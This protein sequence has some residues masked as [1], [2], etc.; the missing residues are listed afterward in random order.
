M[1]I[2]ALSNIEHDGVSY[3]AG[4]ELEVGKEAGDLLVAAGVAQELK[5]VKKEE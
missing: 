3:K 5:S 1:R 4:D 2:K